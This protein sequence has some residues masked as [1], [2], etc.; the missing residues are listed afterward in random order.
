MTCDASIRGKVIPH[1][2]PFRNGTARL[3]MRIPKDAKGKLLRVKL[4]ILLGNESARRIATY[5][6]R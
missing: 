1:V 4:E 3:T 6:V 2:E 5:R